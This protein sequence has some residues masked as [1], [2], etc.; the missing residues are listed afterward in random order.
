MVLRVLF[1]HRN[2]IFVRCHGYVPA[3]GNIWSGYKTLVL[4]AG[5]G[6]VLVQVLQKRTQ[7]P[8]CGRSSGSVP[9]RNASAGEKKAEPSGGRN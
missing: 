8:G 2:G 4:T 5:K 6:V 9:G 1:S 3:E 7:R